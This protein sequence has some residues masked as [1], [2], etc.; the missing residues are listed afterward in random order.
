LFAEIS[1]IIIVT[2]SHF[3]LTYRDCVSLADIKSQVLVM[4][5]RFTSVSAWLTFIHETVATLDLISLYTSGN[6]TIVE[7]SATLVLP[8]VPS[9]LTGDIALWSALQLD[10]D[11]IQ[12]VSESAPVGLGYCANLG[13]NWCNVAY[14]LTPDAENGNPVIAAPGGR[15]Q[16]HCTL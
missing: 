3:N 11:F 1:S 16:T 12:G 6:S 7:A 14:A 8:G 9:P 5:G 4:K 13:S 15:V 10:R 2:K